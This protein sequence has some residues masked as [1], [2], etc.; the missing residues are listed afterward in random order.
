MRSRIALAIGAVTLLALAGCASQPQT[1]D[2]TDVASDDAVVVGYAGAVQ[3]NPNNKAIEDAMRVKVTELG[4][5][6][7]VTDAQ[8]DVSKQLSDVQSLINRDI[9]VLV[10]PASSVLL[11]SRHVSRT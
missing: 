1:T 3:S 2:P 7:I 8:F 4:G 6:L 11:M 5:E 9:D 10:I